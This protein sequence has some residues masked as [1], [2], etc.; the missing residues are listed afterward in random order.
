M[1]TVPDPEPNTV[2]VVDRIDKLPAA[3]MAASC[4]GRPA[5]NSVDGGV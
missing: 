5:R 1:P 2:L 4:H 3:A